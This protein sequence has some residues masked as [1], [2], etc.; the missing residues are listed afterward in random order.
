M[1]INPVKHIPVQ[2]EAE[3]KNKAPMPIPGEGKD[4][5][6]SLLTSRLKEKEVTQSPE[7]AKAI[8]YEVRPGDSLWKIGVR[9]FHKN[10]QQIARDNG[11]TNPD[12]IRP[13]QKLLIYLEQKYEP[14]EARTAK[15]VTACW[16]GMEHQ[17]KITAG[18]HPFDAYKNTVAHRTLPLGTKVRLVN[19]ENGRT[20]VG[21]VTDRGPF[22][23]GRDLDVSLAL[24]KKLGFVRKGVTELEIEVIS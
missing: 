1:G 6:S 13:G 20:A 4:A 22:I 5:F 11:L 19:P 9:L 10:P 24:A 8:E 21:R 3:F 17:N 16:Y 2:V 15:K 7:R 14:T 23:R 18:G 12:L